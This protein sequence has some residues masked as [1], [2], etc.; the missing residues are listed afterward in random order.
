MAEVGRDALLAGFAA[1]AAR[2]DAAELREV[3]LDGR[4]AARRELW[5]RIAGE[6]ERPFDAVPAWRAA[7]VEA[8]RGRRLIALAFDGRRLD[9]ASARLWIDDLIEAI[10]GA[11]ARRAPVWPRRPQL[12]RAPAAGGVE[13]VEPVTIGWRAARIAA[14]RARALFE[15]GRRQGATP[16]ATAAAL[17]AVILARRTGRAEVVLETAAPLRTGPLQRAAIGPLTTSCA[18]EIR[19]AGGPSF[20][21][22]VEQASRALCRAWAAAAGL[23]DAGPPGPEVIADAS[24]ALELPATGRDDTWRE[25]ARREAAAAPLAVALRRTAAGALLARIG[26]DGVEVGADDAA[27]IAAGLDD[28]IA[29]LVADPA[30]AL[31]G[32]APGPA[33]ADE[34]A[35][36]APHPLSHAQERLWFLE[37]L[38]PGT[39][40]NHLQ[41]TY[42]LSGALDRDALARSLAAMSRRH[43]G[44]RTVF[45]TIDAAPHQLVAREMALE[46]RVDVLPPATADEHA[47]WI[48]ERAADD[49]ARPFEL[50][51]GPLW[52][53]RLCCVAPGDHRLVLTIHHLIVDALSVLVW[54]RELVEY[55]HA[56]LAGTAPR[57]GRITAT[58]AD[59]AVWERSPDGQRRIADDLAFWLGELAG[60]T[61]L[62]LPI[63]HRR[64]PTHGLG[65][66]EVSSPLPPDRAAQIRALGR[67]HGATLNIALIAAAAAFLARH[68][69]Q[70]DLVCI[71][72]A[73]RRDDPGRRNAIGLLLN[74]LP[75]RLRLDG[76]PTFAE[77][78][79]R[80]QRAMHRALAHAEAP[81]ERIIAGLGLPRGPGRQPLFDVI[82]N[83]VPGAERLWWGD[84]KVTLDVVIGSAQPCDL[85]IGASTRVGGTLGLTVR[86]RDDLFAPITATRM[87]ARFRTLLLA[88][89][90]A[91][92]TRLSE[93]PIMPD[94]ERDTVV[95]AWNRTHVA[96]PEATVHGLVAARI[97]ERP[98]AVAVI[99]GDRA[100]TYRE[101]GRR[102]DRLAA[103][104]AARVA[105]GTRVGVLVPPSPELAIAALGVLAAGA[106]YVPFD[107]AQPPARLAV[108]AREVELVVGDPA[109]AAQ[110]AAPSLA[111][112]ADD[113]EPDV[114]IPDLQRHCPTSPDAP[115]YIVFTSG[116]TGGPKGVATSH[117]ALVNQIAWFA[118][119]L[120]W[121][122]GEV[123]CLRSSPAFVDS[124]WELFGPL[125][126]GVPLVIATTAEMADPRLL[127]AAAERHAVTRIVVVPSLLRTLLELGAGRRDFLP[128]LTLWLATSEELRPALVEAFFAARSGQRLVNL[129]G[130]S[131]TAD[132]VAAH[133]V[134]PGDARGARTPIGRPIANS[135]IYVLD[136]AG[137]ALPVGVPGELCVAGVG[138]SERYLGD[139][140]A[141]AQAR[142]TR[143]PFA[144]GARMYRSGDRGRWRYDGLLEYIGR[145]EH[146]LKVRGI[147]IDPGEVENALLAHPAVAAAAV[148][149]RPGFDGEDRLVAYVVARGGERPLSD[150]LRPFLRARLPEPLIPTAFVALAAL[151]L[152][153]TGKVD[154]AAL[155]APAMA[156][157]ASRLPAGAFEHAVALAWEQLLGRPVGAEDDFFAAGGQSLLAAQLGARLTE[158]FAVELPLAVLFERPTIAAQARWL[159]AAVMRAPNTGIARIGDA[160]APLSFAQERLWFSAALAHKAPQ[161]KLRFAFRLDGPLDT[162][163]LEAAMLAIAAR[164]PA[165]RTVFAGEGA[166]ARQRVVASCPRDHRSEDVSALPA[167]DQRA[168][169]ARH[170][171]AERD[172][173]F[174]LA[175]GPP[176]RTRLL[177]LGE[178]AHVLILGLHHYVGDGI[179]VQ[180]WLEEL[181]AH[182]SALGAGTAPTVPELGT[183]PADIAAWQRRMADTG[184][185]EPARAYWRRTL[186]GAAPL[187]LPLVAPRTRWATGHS[188]SARAELAGSD[189]DA[190]A[191]LARSVETTLFGALLA[192]AAAL[193]GRL[194][195]STD[196][197]LGTVAGGRE[198]PEF[199]PLIGL[200]LNPL[201]LRLSLDG[202]P[203]GRA[204]IAAAGRTVRGAL[205]HSDVPFERIVA[206][207]NPE[208]RPYRQPLFDAVINHQPPMPQPR[209]GEVALSHLRDPGAPV[210]PYELMIRTIVRADSLSVQIDYQRERFADDAVASWL[211][212]YVELLRRFIAA[213]DRRLSQSDGR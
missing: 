49:Y 31:A 56:D 131:E 85:V 213:P 173:P 117:R 207:A 116:S 99:Q 77:I 89:V 86:C 34:P 76:D 162:D 138:I 98:D 63:D 2:G 62:E 175:S 5:Q 119:D 123:S 148:A 59:V 6:L 114:S 37:N 174:A 15:T 21:A 79:V 150:E 124:L 65:R 97:R 161:P 202:D 36:S 14:G 182:Y 19:L 129:Y 78:V 1:M 126:D 80:T 172:R 60:A 158:H 170:F 40:V 24:L 107:A 203:S 144:P 200:F 193:L 177:R 181:D 179:S 71:V 82:L 140:P 167:A 48:T 146:L 191:E 8:A 176:W 20:A 43:D 159:E 84:L 26:Y 28:L 166:A 101:L 72:P 205:A 164:Q 168:A 156:P 92:H 4:G 41:R 211:G 45:R 142:F 102:A 141:A 194:A 147:R 70:D 134:A 9:A 163:R 127:A 169:I 52:R 50:A 106:V 94:D 17:V 90:A 184:F 18:I 157:I 153:P 160:A 188:G 139:A 109:L 118:R 66:H 47:R 95:E 187:D 113:S 209:L 199:R 103:A 7:I 22:I 186:A 68:T 23:V 96:L 81:F 208:R 198:R 51:N 206:D 165:L 30:R 190:L 57:L 201:P 108:L 112:E 121:Q 180:L 155:P 58:V 122:P 39:T 67:R 197:T 55:Y 61:P 171:E 135:Q 132:Q 64:P 33:P 83:M 44:L 105:P 125:A 192:A 69:E 183:G 136:R 73:S 111:L 104:L 88:A 115:C 137:R 178:S 154:R 128:R 32:L 210:T 145:F 185:W 143:N 75:L 27:D 120:P 151:P 212:S 91:P 12:P 87:M 42:R 133:E 152:G 130:A 35:M 149:A 74:L 16:L 3:R 100:V 110:I 93:L 53:T 204:L 46:H 25:A 29:E 189:A 195:G 10:H 196:V 13:V 38:V 54:Y 11:A